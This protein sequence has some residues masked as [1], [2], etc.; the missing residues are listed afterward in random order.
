[1]R[2]AAVS[3]GGRRQHAGP[4]LQRSSP[5]SWRRGS[6][7]SSRLVLAG[8]GTGVQKLRDSHAQGTAT[9]GRAGP[10]RRP[11][12][13]P[14]KGSVGPSSGSWTSR[15]RPGEA[16]RGRSVPARPAAAV[17]CAA[18]TLYF[19]VKPQLKRRGRG[20]A[21]R[22]S[23][24]S[25]LWH[26][27]PPSP[28]PAGTLPPSPARHVRRRRLSHTTL[29]RNRDGTGRAE[30][31]HRVRLQA[32]RQAK[33]Y[34]GSGSGLR[35]PPKQVAFRLE[36]DGEDLGARR[37]RKEGGGVVAGA[38]PRSREVGPIGIQSPLRGAARG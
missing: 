18:G 26:R 28:A 25:A 11:A 32:R 19:A 36:K 31:A 10:G 38:Q 21:S 27:L 2:V 14:H 5:A 35:H 23:A 34:T 17:R 6:E 24:A 22:A 29:V 37:G 13:H 3:G 33:E 9:G 1:M 7:A 15:G 16:R 8:G 20:E 4:Q 12:R 30:P